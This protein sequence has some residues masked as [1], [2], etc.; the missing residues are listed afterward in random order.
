MSEVACIISQDS[1]NLEFE[2]KNGD[3]LSNDTPFRHLD[4]E[5]IKVSLELLAL[6]RYFIAPLV[7][8][9]SQFRFREFVIG[10]LLENQNRFNF[11]RI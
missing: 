2:R 3:M 10:H 9:V 11:G 7:E 5:D 6:K 8:P 4:G 1:V